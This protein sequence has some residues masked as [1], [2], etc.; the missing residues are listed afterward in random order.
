M[1]QS[2]PMSLSERDLALLSVVA[3]VLG[4]E[5][6]LDGFYTRVRSALEGL[7]LELVLR[8]R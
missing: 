7:P 6:T 4:E 3:P 1:L 8:P 5:D 2:A